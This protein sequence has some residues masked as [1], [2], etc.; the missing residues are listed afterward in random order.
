MMRKW[1][2]IPIVALG[3]ALAGCSGEDSPRGGM[4]QNPGT[5]TLATVQTA[6]FSPSCAKTNCHIGVDAPFGLDLSQGETMGNV[7]GVASAEMPTFDRVE[8]FNADDSYLYM[9]VTSDPR[10]TGDPMPADGSTL[11][12]GQLDLLRRWIEQGAN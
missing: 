6:V 7:R 9:K 2:A 4:T 8:P 12:S 5:V 11:T 10:I 1:I 3:L